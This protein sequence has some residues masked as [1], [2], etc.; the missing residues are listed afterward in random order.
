M[1]TNYISS[2]TQNDN[3][4]FKSL[5][6]ICSRVYNNTHLPPPL[7]QQRVVAEGAHERGAVVAQLLGV[8]VA[9]VRQQAREVGRVALR[10]PEQ[11]ARQRQVRVQPAQEA[12]DGRA[13]CGHKHP[14]Y[15]QLHSAKFRSVY[16]KLRASDLTTITSDRPVRGGGGRRG[17]HPVAVHRHRQ[18]GGD[19]VSVDVNGSC[20]K[21]L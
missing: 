8:G 16:D 6:S 15:T 11:H 1:K 5:A 9:L 7:A 3:H 10:L 2:I 21:L 13:R 19:V 14:R 12:V 17:Y 20:L 4:A 18:G